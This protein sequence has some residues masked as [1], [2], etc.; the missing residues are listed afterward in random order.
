MGNYLF[1]NFTDATAAN[2]TPFN[3]YVLPIC[4]L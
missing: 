1:E 2:Y 4:Y 3:Y